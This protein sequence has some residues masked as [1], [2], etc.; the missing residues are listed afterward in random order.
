[1]AT[2]KLGVEVAGAHDLMMPNGQEFPG[3]FVML[4]FDFQQFRT[5]IKERGVNPVWDESFYFD[6]SD[7]SN[8]HKIV[9]EASVYNTNKSIQQGENPFLGKVRIN[10]AS[11][12][13][14]RDAV[15]SR[16]PLEKGG[17]FSHGVRGGLGLKVYIADEASIRAQ[18][19]SIASVC[20]ARM[21]LCVEVLCARDLV[22]PKDD[23]SS[24][25]TCVEL[26]FDYFRSCTAI[27]EKDPNP[28]WNER[29]Y[30]DLRDPSNLPEFFLEA[31]VY[32]VN[33][34]IKGDKSLLGKARIEGD[35]IV[36]ISRAVVLHYALEKRGMLSLGVGGEL[37]LKLYTIDGPS[38]RR[39]LNPCLP[40]DSTIYSLDLHVSNNL[41]ST[42][43]NQGSGPHD[44]PLSILE[45]ITNNFSDKR[46]IGQ[47]GVGVV[48]KGVLQNG[49]MIAVKKIV[50]LLMPN[51]KKKFENEVSH[52]IR[53]KHPNIVRCVGYC[54]ETRNACVEYNGELVFVE[55]AER[56]IC[57]EYMSKGS[58]E[59]YLSDESSGLDWSTRYKIIKGICNGLY[60]LYEETH[61]PIMH[62]DLKPANILLDDRMEPKITDFGLSRLFDHEETIHT[63]SRDGTL[64]YM[65]PEFIHAGT[66]TPKSDI[67]S[68]GVIILE[69]IT[70]HRDY[71]DVTRESSDVF[72]ELVLKKWRN[73]LERAPEYRSLEIECQQI[74][75]CIQVGLICVNP[76]RGK[77]PPIAKIINMLQGPKS[78]DCSSNEVTLPGCFKS[79]GLTLFIDYDMLKSLPKFSLHELK[80]ACEDFT[81][82]IVSTPETVVY[83]G[84]RETRIEFSFGNKVLPRR[85]QRLLMHMTE[86]PIEHGEISVISCPFEGRWTSRHELVYQN[87][88]I[89]LARSDHGNIARLMGYCRESDPFAR[90]VVFEYYETLNQHLHWGG[91]ND[92]FWHMRMRIASGIAQGLKYLHTELQPPIAI[93]E[94]NS[95]S[96]YVTEE[97]TAKLVDFGCFKTMFSKHE[98]A[99]S[100][101]GPMDSSED[102]HADIQGN[103]FAFGVILLEIISGRLPYCKDKGYLVDWASK[104]LKRPEEMKK[105]VDPR[106]TDVQTEDLAVICSVVRRCIDPDPSKRPSMQI[107]ARALGTGISTDVYS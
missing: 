20:R 98:N 107:I 11:F 61:K 32:S 19:R 22:M 64:G 87:K 72:I 62:L 93:S 68:L 24:S 21:G 95:N 34:F 63:S 103:T 105:L 86:R 89:D 77:R 94:L 75:T 53:L 82:V 40:M 2:C 74:K 4:T 100:L 46:I 101:P 13:P 26:S 30:F 92:L 41:T 14:F 51:M 6:I 99:A 31:C 12:Q 66:I 65:A 90:M 23:Q 29:F 59:N 35:S 27:K 104:Y 88:V 67:F 10:G 44:V 83:K 36:P 58:L 39:T 47:G 79:N 69:I 45:E 76:E 16:Y 18:E 5:T 91:P 56:L 85:T 49:E 7:P 50:S 71:P 106:L 48:Y 102:R 78:V 15:R 25:G 17:M 33:K 42:L 57:L 55:R 80:V 96:V 37:S 38:I 54:Y 8:L 52:L 73:T 70:G 9:L 60:H 84:T 28:V 97:Y 3:V 81:N 43:Q 1:M